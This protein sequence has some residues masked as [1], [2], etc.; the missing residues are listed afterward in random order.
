[1]ALTNE[2]TGAA[3]LGVHWKLWMAAALTLAG[4]GW[5]A[6]CA[7][8]APAERVLR[9]SVFIRDDKGQAVRLALAR[10]YLLQAQDLGEMA[11]AAA[12]VRKERM[13]GVEAAQAEMAAEIARAQQSEV[14]PRQ[15]LEAKEAALAE[16][17]A[18]GAEKYGMVYLWEN[19]VA[20][21]KA[22]L[23]KVALLNLERLK[24]YI[25]RFSELN[26]ETAA[27]IMQAET[28]PRRA[29]IEAAVTDANGDFT[30]TIP[31]GCDTLMIHAETKGGLA[32]WMVPAEQLDYSK[33]P[34]LFSEH[35]RKY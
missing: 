25:D 20:T 1:M 30:V 34:F 10:V 12:L 2:P 35:N 26:R 19:D 23:A 8:Q 13:P 21:A 33:S 16:V 14:E 31:P 28:T 32:V 27:A 5:C 11:A 18:R 7:K 24:P 29:L 15:V 4:A 17:R 6:S 9:G 22:A 3:Y